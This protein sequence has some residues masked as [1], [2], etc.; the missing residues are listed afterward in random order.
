MSKKAIIP[1]AII[2]LLILGLL[3]F[4]VLQRNKDIRQN[5]EDTIGN[6]GG[7]LNNGG[8]FVENDDTIFFANAYDEGSLYR[9]DKDFSNIKRL[10]G[11]GVAYMNLG[12]DY[13]YYY[14][15]NS[16]A[17]SSLGFVVHVSGLYRSDLKG[18]HVLCLDK[19]DCD[20]VVLIGNKVYYTKAV[21]GQNTLC[22]HSITTSKKDP[23]MLTNFLLNP[24][25]VSGGL[26]YY[27][28][29]E[30]NHY[31]YTYDTRTNNSALV[32]QYDMWFPVYYGNSVYFLDLSSNYRLC[33][34]DLADGNVTV[35]TNE[36]VDCFNVSG[37]VAYYQTVG[38]DPGLYMVGI[39][40][41]NPSLLAQGTYHNINI[42]G[43]YVFYQSYQTEI[44]MYMAPVGSTAV[45]TFD[46]AKAAAMQSMAKK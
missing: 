22:L 9:M 2:M 34:L 35:L 6:T 42:A 23:T 46:D 45:K 21:D 30:Q 12:G 16:S 44:P 25:S 32:A 26:I 41:S 10:S 3:I 40:G 39:D 43:G 36:R 28:G 4:F 27:N 17:A 14:Q 33:R 20:R 29:T 8:Y 38:S 1:I 19:V 18:E 37:G 24:A 7:N 15:K 5:P 13:L 31:L 11:A